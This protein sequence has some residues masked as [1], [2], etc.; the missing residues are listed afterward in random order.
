M[1]KSRTHQI[2]DL[3]QR[4]L[5]DAL[6]P[7]W[8]INDH[9][10]DYAKDYLV[11][12]GEDNGELT[13]SSFYIQLKGQEK[14]EF[15]P[16]GS[17]V[18]YSL[19][20]KYARYYLD[21]I[22]D[23]PVFLVVVDVN[24]KKGWWMFL[25]PALDAT[26]IWRRRGSTTVRLPADN[27][28]MSTALF[29]TAIDDAKK[30]MRLHHPVSIHEAVAAHKERITRIDPRFDVAV[31]L[32]NDKPIFNLLAKEKVPL[33]FSFAGNRDEI[34]RKVS[35]FLDKGAL[36]E[37]QPGEVKISGSK[38]FEQIEQQGCSLQAKVSLAGTLSLE[39]RDMEGRELARLSDVPGRFTGGQRELWFEGGL[40]NS[41]LALK[42][43]PIA[44][45]IGGSVRLNLDLHR[46]NGQRL[47]QLA[48]FDRL[49][50]FLQALPKSTSTT[51]ECQHDGNCVFSATLPLQNLP[52]TS[53]LACYLGSLSNAR[54]IAQRFNVNPEWTVEAFDGDNQET[55]DEL[56]AIFFGN[57]RTRPMP[58]V[59]LKANCIRKTFCYDVAK[60]ASDRGFVRLVG[61]SRY[62]WFGQIVEVGKLVHDYSEMSI[63]V[64]R[65][66]M[67]STP[68]K[69]RKGRKK[70]PSNKDTVEIAL[71]GSEATVMRVQSE[72]GMSLEPETRL[73][74]LSER[75]NVTLADRP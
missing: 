44:L 22:R 32:V 75:T 12:I 29:R 39:C 63:E 55:A 14:A 31:S 50:Q 19:K 71:I 4:F 5:R 2:D 53:P 28:M 47:M 73:S 65:E 38:L 17:M 30:W 51:V 34:A 11:E 1:K 72:K 46:W 42:L 15:S 48:Y 20:S 64:I 58:H 37:F 66:K 18:K 3:A 24:Q 56:H 59:R 49:S 8:V 10:N 21:K 45:G 57:G 35:D 6:P 13:G 9:F 26:P 7:T 52:F 27:N 70:I 62:T 60:V 36:V 74:L 25:Q 67:P 54:L 41:P 33:T 61:D 40:A 69:S 23:L 43:G 16:D 68:H